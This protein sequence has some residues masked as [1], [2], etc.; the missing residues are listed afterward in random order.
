MHDPPGR[1]EMHVVSWTVYQ[2]GEERARSARLEVGSE[3]LG[4][5][6]PE[7]KTGSRVGLSG[8]AV[9]ASPLEG[10]R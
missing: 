9:S 1:V 7:C 3:G 10:E 8:G 6:T 4:G 2:A 5:D